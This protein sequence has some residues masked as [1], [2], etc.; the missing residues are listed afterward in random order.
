MWVI[1]DSVTEV[2][3]NYYPQTVLEECKY[4]IRKIKIEN[5]INDELYPRSSDESE[6]ELTLYMTVNLIM[7]LTINLLINLRIK[8]IF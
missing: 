5:L 1:V 6:S 3:K 7:N 8:I 2:N 4:E